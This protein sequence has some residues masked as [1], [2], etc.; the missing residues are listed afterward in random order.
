M[1]SRVQVGDEAGTLDRHGYRQIC[2]GY[3]LVKAHRIAWFLYY[4]EWPK[5]CI[6]H[7]NGIKTDNRIVNLRDVNHRWNNQNLHAA[8]DGSASRFLGVSLDGMRWRAQI[9]VN[10]KNRNLGRFNTEQE[11]YAAYISA[12]RKLHDGNKL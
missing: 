1:S 3:K 12:K 7:V 9:R 11:A 2:I 4:G 5:N 10:G 6:D 8:R